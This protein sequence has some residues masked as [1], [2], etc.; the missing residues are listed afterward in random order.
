M[1]PEFF[2]K[3]K[4]FNLIFFQSFSFSTIF[5]V[6]K[7]FMIFPFFTKC[8]NESSM[9]KSHPGKEGKSGEGVRVMGK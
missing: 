1:I 9:E 6:D 7:N 2:P 3:C 8:K 5:F 4:F